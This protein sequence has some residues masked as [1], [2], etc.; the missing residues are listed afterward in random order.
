M[1]D[2]PFAPPM[3]AA[4]ADPRRWIAFVFL[5]LASFMNLMDVTIVNVALPSMQKNLGATPTDIEW[6]VSAYVLA[7]ALGLLPFGRLG[8]IVGRKRMFLIGVTLFTLGSLLCGIAP[9]IDLL[10]GARV[11]QGLAA[12]AMTPQV[13]AIAQVTFPPTEKGLMFSLFGLSASLAAVCGP[14]IGGALIAANIAG[15]DWRPIFLVNIPLGAIAVTAGAL[16]VRRVPPHPGLR[17][18]YIGIGIFGLAMIA[19]VYPLIEGHEAGWPAWVFVTLGVSV[20]LM[21]AF[22]FWQKRRHAANATQLLPLELLQNRN[23]LLGMLMTTLFASGVPGS[24]VV[25]AIFLQT[26]FGLSPLQ[27]G[28]TT[29]PFSLGVMAA[30]LLAGRL[31]NRFLSPRVATGSLLLAAGFAYLI[32]ELSQV[33]DQVNEWALLPP[34]VIAGIGLGTTFGALFQT[35]LSGVP[36]KDAGSASGALQAF[37]Q[38][39]GALGV[40]MIGEV[41]FTWLENGQAWGATSKSAAFVNAATHALIYDIVVFVVVAGLVTL[42]KPLPMLVGAQAP[43][44]PVVVEV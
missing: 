29:V 28:L 43:A 4:S 7:F 31:G 35:I 42:L 21:G 14:I 24:F 32:Y 2:K 44:A 15:L 33:T 16:V 10:I 41:F 11:L 34:F 3:D 19:L 9:S 13:L 26:G 39:G 8:D 37:Q 22:Y 17:N 23:F 5:L 18:D 20:G 27:S 36:H 40:A 12:S 1:T 38:V 25:I 6:V 30:S